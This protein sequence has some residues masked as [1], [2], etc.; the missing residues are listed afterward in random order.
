MKFVTKI[1]NT[2][3]EKQQSNFN[4]KRVLRPFSC[5]LQSHK[6]CKENS[7]IT[8]DKKF[9]EVVIHKVFHIIGCILLFMKQWIKNPKIISFPECSNV[10]RN[11]IFLSM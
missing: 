5:S 8:S 4:Q 11:L 1:P 6:Q 3:S 7:R 10:S 2:R 9:I